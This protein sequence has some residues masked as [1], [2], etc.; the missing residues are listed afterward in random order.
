MLVKNRLRK[1]HLQVDGDILGEADDED[2]E[3]W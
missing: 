2:E 1:G 3:M